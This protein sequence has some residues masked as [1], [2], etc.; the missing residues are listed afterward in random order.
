MS[1]ELNN[2]LNMNNKMFKIAAIL[3]Y[4]NSILYEHISCFCLFLF[5]VHYYVQRHSWWPWNVTITM[6]KLTDISC[7]WWAKGSVSVSN[8][9]ESYLLC[10]W[11]RNSCPLVITHQRHLWTLI[12]VIT[13][14]RQTC[15]VETL[16]WGI[17]NYMTWNQ[18]SL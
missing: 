16:V 2:T 3:L 5:S 1:Y 13:C 18:C 15:S 4:F 11:Y 8:W 6:I 7:G 14:W 12:D 17:W 9:W 10:T